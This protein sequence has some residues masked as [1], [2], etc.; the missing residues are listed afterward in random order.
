[1]SLQGQAGA[2]WLLPR[3]PLGSHVLSALVHDACHMCSICGYLQPGSLGTLDGLGCHGF[4]FSPSLLCLCPSLYYDG[5][6]LYYLFPPSA[7]FDLL[8]LFPSLFA[9][10]HPSSLLVRIPKEE[11]AWLTTDTAAP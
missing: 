7:V 8:L 1:M 3:M 9:F 2:G 6:L 5:V 4:G 11:V 10:I